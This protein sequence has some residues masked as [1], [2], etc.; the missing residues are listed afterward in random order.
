M[1]AP[2]PSRTLQRKTRSTYGE[3]AA[4]DATATGSDRIG[5]HPD[6]VSAPLGSP[7]GGAVADGCAAPEPRTLLFDSRNRRAYLI[8]QSVQGPHR[9]Y[10]G[11]YNDRQA[12]HTAA[13][14]VLLAGGDAKA[15]AEAQKSA[16]SLIAGPVPM[17]SPHSTADGRRNLSVKFNSTR[18]HLGS[19][20]SEST[21]RSAL[22]TF[23]T[24]AEDQSLE[25]ARQ[26]AK[27]MSIDT[28]VDII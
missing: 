3:G 13:A 27:R 4:P 16:R 5:G 19:F 25:V 8:V 17:F 20:R 2:T 14:A 6:G 1:S 21:A 22:D 15:V 11:R 10:I 12:A 23:L 24:N 28:V 9:L 26:A 18:L 7:S